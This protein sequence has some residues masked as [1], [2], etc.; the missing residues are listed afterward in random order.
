MIEGAY[1]WPSYPLK[2]HGYSEDDPA[3]R[4][5]DYTI[6]AFSTP[7]TEH[8][9]GL[10]AQ[11]TDRREFLAD[12]ARAL[13]LDPGPKYGTLQRG[14][15]V[16]TDDGRTV[17]PDVVLSDPKPGRKIVY[18]GDTKPT[19]GVVEAA[20]DASL[21]I[22]SAM[23]ADEQAERARSTGHST[24]TEA[25]QVAAE[26]N[27]RQLWLTHISPRHE[28]DE[29]TLAAQAGDAFD[30]DIA[31]VRDGDTTEVTRGQL[32]LAAPW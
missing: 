32:R 17:I 16:E 6:Q 30:G 28:D 23:F 21:L 31:A 26:S 5:E 13:G 9:H 22:Y 27:S 3:I 18:T 1:E 2:I 4:T 8:S 15:A 12:E 10:I 24:A 19:A 20:A 25:G 11:E 14:H 7:Y 29:Q